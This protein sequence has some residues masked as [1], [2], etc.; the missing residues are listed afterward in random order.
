MP[1]PTHQ[2]EQQQQQQNTEQQRSLS[3]IHDL[4]YLSNEDGLSDEPQPILAVPNSSNTIVSTAVT[5]AP[6]QEYDRQVVNI[7]RNDQQIVPYQDQG[8]ILLY[9][10]P[11]KKQRNVTPAP[12]G[13]TSSSAMSRADLMT[14]EVIAQYDCKFILGTTRPTDGRCGE[15]VALDQHAVGERIE[16]ERM[17]QHLNDGTGSAVGGKAISCYKVC[18]RKSYTGQRA[19]TFMKHKHSLHQW[20]FRFASVQLEESDTTNESTLKVA[21]SKLPVVFGR[22]QTHKVLDNFLDEIIDLARVPT[23]PRFVTI[24]LKQ[25]ACH[26]AVKFGMYLS[27]EQA[28]TLIEDLKKCQYPFTCCHGR[29][30]IYPLA[31]MSLIKNLPRFNSRSVEESGCACSNLFFGSGHN[32]LCDQGEPQEALEWC[33][34]CPK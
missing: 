27:P 8:A 23:R 9:E 18:V 32:F 11:N 19:S 29:P 34:P 6:L 14:I 16:E 31:Q 17:I 20:G 13:A 2:F 28:V 22:K 30:T 4:P 5:R 15:L 7:D 21:V 26:T 1:L 12:T 33:P 24:S 3:A 10:P 25:H